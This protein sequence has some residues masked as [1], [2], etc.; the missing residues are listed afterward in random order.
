M[1]RRAFFVVLLAAGT[2]GLLA[3]RFFAAPPLIVWNAT[4][5]VPVGLYLI[6]R[7][8]A[9]RVGDLALLRLDPGSAARFAARGYLP[10][11]VPLLKPVGAI[12]GT[13]V[14]EREGA[15]SI[16]GKH[17][18][19]AQATDGKGRPIAAW[20]GC[21]TLPSDELLVLNADNL[22]SLDGRYFGPSPI[23]AV[24]GR[25]LPLWTLEAR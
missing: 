7:A 24:I 20:E 8:D 23:T 9:L 16:A 22:A 13:M 2:H 11:G 6:V 15:V 4:P 19:D 18:A 10:A 14:C 12:A 1:R 5:S 3:S 21:R 25:A 17:V